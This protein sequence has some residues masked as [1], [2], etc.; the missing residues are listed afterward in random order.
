MVMNERVTKHSDIALLLAAVLPNGKLPGKNGRFHKSAFDSVSGARIS[1]VT[2]VA[3]LMGLRVF[4]M[5]AVFGYG[6]L[7]KLRLCR[8]NRNCFE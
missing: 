7:V 8:M 4:R 5:E 2:A 6:C 1:E 3:V